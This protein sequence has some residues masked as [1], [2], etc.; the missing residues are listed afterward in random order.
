[1]V[2]EDQKKS[3]YIIN[4]LAYYFKN[5][6]KTG[7]VLVLLGEKYISQDI[8]FK[9]IIIEIFGKLY[10]SNIDDNSD[11]KTSL[12]QDVA[13]DK[14]FL[15]V[16]TI[17]DAGTQFDD[18]S[19]ALLIK[20]L[21]IQPIIT[22]TNDNNEQEKLEIHSQVLITATNPAPY[23]KKALSKCSVFNITDIDTI[24]ANLEL[25][26]EIELEDKILKDLDNFSDFLKCYQLKEERAVNK[27][28]TE[29]RELLKD[30][31]TENNINKEDRD[32]KIDD[33]IQAII[34]K[35]L[36]YFVKVKGNKDK[37]GKDIYVQLKN[38]FEKD[39]GYFVTND[40]YLYFNAVYSDLSFKD[41]ST[42]LEFLKEKNSMFNQQYLKLTILDKDGNK[43]ILFEKY[44]SV[45]LG[46]GSKNLL[47][48]N[49]YKS[50]E[51]FIIKA[52]WFAEINDNSF[53]KYT[54]EDIESSKNARQ[55]GKEKDIIK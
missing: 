3:D 15:N 45:D 14:L 46:I 30:K 12:I 29:E 11:Y 4:W 49:G 50:P 27:L 2:G 33:F 51:E 38:T 35:N 1:M 48:I 44:P 40:L 5:L 18:T 47:K 24:M 36:E 42:L 7:T 25:E 28:I 41:N 54:Y 32:S 16:G 55:L 13:K 52:G 10:C 23:L 19:L 6:K 17:D 31:I 34:D 8:F 43:E 53:K 37:Q 22:F 9:R 39:E 20:E 21:L 26:D